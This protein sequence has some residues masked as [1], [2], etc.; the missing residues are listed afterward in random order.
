MPGLVGKVFPAGLEG[1]IMRLV[2]EIIWLCGEGGW[3]R[4]VFIVILFGGIMR[5]AGGFSLLRALF[6][7]VVGAVPLALVFET[8]FW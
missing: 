1:E 3:A 6:I 5:K 2:G 4:E 8:L 7:G